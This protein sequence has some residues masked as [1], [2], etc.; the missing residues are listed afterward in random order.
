[1]SR[2]DTIMAMPAWSLVAAGHIDGTDHD[3][4]TRLQEQLTVILSDPRYHT[5]LSELRVDGEQPVRAVLHT[6]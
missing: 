3:A 5:A 6:E 2:A 1:M 4:T